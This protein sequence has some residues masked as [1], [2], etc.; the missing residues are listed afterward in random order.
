VDDYSPLPAEFEL[1]GD[2]GQPRG[3]IVSDSGRW[4]LPRGLGRGRGLPMIAPEV[5][6]I[7]VNSEVAGTKAV[8]SRRLGE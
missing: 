7:E 2:R 6:E 5:D 1:L 8:I 3:I 4:R